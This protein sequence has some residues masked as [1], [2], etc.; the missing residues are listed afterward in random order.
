MKVTARLEC[1]K[2]AMTGEVKAAYADCSFK[3]F[4]RGLREIAGCLKEMWVQ[5]RF[6]LVFFGLF[7]LFFKMEEA[8]LYTC[9]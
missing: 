3:T 4:E 7:V 1:G 5:D 9:A 2:R 6:S 8:Y